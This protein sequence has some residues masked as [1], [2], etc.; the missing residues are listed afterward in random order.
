MDD[1]VK[2]MVQADPSKRPT[3]DVVVPRFQHIRG[4]LSRH[5]LR[6]RVAHPDEAGIEAAFH[7]VAHLFRRIKY[8]LRG[9]PSIPSS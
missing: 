3:M 8:T 1:L 5:T 9:T 2:D 6:S 7:S 4:K